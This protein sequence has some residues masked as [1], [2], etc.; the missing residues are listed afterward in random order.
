M[1]AN[2]HESLDSKVLDWVNKQGCSLEMRV[3]Q[4]FE[5]AGFE[6]S[7]FE[8]YLDAQT[9]ELREIDVVA[10][11]NRQID[12][13]NVSVAL[14]VECKYLRNPWVV[15]TSS[16]RFGPFSYFSRILR[17]KYDV[18]RWKRQGNLQ[19]RLLARIVLSVGRDKI[20]KYRFFSMPQNAGYGITE[21]L[22]RDPKAKDN[23]YPAIMQAT[24]CA[25]AHDS[26]IEIIFQ[27]AVEEYEKRMYDTGVGRGELSI[28]CGIAFPIVVVDGRLFECYL[29]SNNEICI[30]EASDSV[31][32]LSKKSR[33]EEPRAKPSES[34]VRVVTQGGAESFAKEAHQAA[35]ALL[36]QDG[37]IRGLWEHEYLKL[38]EKTGID[39]IPF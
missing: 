24:K 26:E 28:L 35:T 13:I 17:G 12:A 31:V 32:I 9:S 20:R 10:S 16:R 29:D 22:R 30:L 27:R 36:S 34:V 21:S 1:P 7:Q 38:P 37:A 6:V 15:F 4:I 25:E 8:S 14:F 33:D 2:D 5:K 3:A 39:E 19:G 23:A 11:I 18:H